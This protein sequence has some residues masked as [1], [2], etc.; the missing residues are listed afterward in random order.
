MRSG[1]LRLQYR[2]MNLPILQAGPVSDPAQIARLFLQ[3]Q[4]DW[5]RHLG[6]EHDLPLGTAI[7]NLKLPRVPAA[8]A[9]F[10][11]DLPGGISPAAALEEAQAF[12]RD[13]GAVLR[14]VV[15][16]AMVHGGPLME[17][18]ATAGWGVKRLR[19]LRLSRTLER[20]AASL[21]QGLKIIPARASFRHARQLADEMAAGDS[22]LAEAA[23]L[24][25]DDPH[26]DALL[27][28]E[29]GKAVAMIAVLAMGDVGRIEQLF[30]SESARRRGLGQVMVS[31]AL[32][33]CAR[34]LFRHVLAGQ[35]EADST[36]GIL[37]GKNGFEE[38]ATVSMYDRVE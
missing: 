17:F 11:A 33:I 8:N 37:L 24:H 21:P 25:L 22:Q 2:P 4:L 19:V 15:P 35:G 30:V 5:S 27:A 14:Y 38:V 29:D 31:R 6:E 16:S 10:N 26:V 23:M 13:S 34:S 1:T 3:T 9:V 18:L 28:L 32:E 7:L 12:F 20:G 36:T